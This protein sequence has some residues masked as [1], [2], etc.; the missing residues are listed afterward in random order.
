MKKSI[1][2]ISILLLI[3]VQ[4]C[5]KEK[6]CPKPVIS[7][8]E[9]NADTDKSILLMPNPASKEAIIQWKGSGFAPSNIKIYD[10]HGKLV[11]QEKW[12][13]NKPHLIDTSK[14]LEGIYFVIIE[15]NQQEKRYKKL[16]IM[17]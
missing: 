3:I 5:F 13:N 12:E 1:L 15:T 4:S 16:V 17:K 11:T 10:I 9:S 8:E 2:L 14:W 7:W 6:K